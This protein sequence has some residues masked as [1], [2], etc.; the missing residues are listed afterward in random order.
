MEL[1]PVRPSSGPSG[2][3]RVGLDEVEQPRGNLT[4]PLAIFSLRQAPAAEASKGNRGGAMHRIGVLSTAWD[5]ASPVLRAF[6]DGLTKLGYI[7]GQDLT[8]EVRSGG[9]RNERLP[10][11]AAE[12]VDLGVEAIVTGGPY[13]LDAA[14][15]ATTTV[16]IV[17]AGVGTNFAPARAEGNLT[18][19]PEQIVELIAPRLDF[20]KE[21]APTLRR[22]AVLAN[23]DNYGTPAYLQE[24]RTWA[25]AAGVT[26]QVYE[27]QDPSDTTPS[28]SKMTGDGV[29]GLIA[30]TDSIIF[31]QRETIVQQAKQHGLP[32]SY[33]Y[34]EWVTAGGLLSY[35]PNLATILREPVPAK[36]HKIL[37]GAR[38]SDI[39]VEQPRLELFINLTTAKA[40]GLSMPQSLLSRADETIE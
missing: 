39:P 31:G 35:G 29:E 24:S 34:R 14:R 8:I 11:L 20:L 17:F 27:V 38:P 4:P 12:L 16:P 28:F 40:I 36:V 6:R 18:G 13:A 2:C 9:G 22:L 26:L 10:A 19:V 37:Q 25:E 32:G 15:D 23:P 33:P 1:G 5:P 21:A 30:F 3:E 7:E